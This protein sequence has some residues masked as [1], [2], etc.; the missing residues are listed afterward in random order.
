MKNKFTVGDKV[1]IPK[2][3][4]QGFFDKAHVIIG[5]VKINDKLTIMKF[6]KSSDNQSCVIVKE[7]A[8]YIPVNLI[9]KFLEPKFK[10]GYKFVINNIRFEIVKSSLNKKLKT[11]SYLCYDLDTGAAWGVEEKEIPVKLSVKPEVKMTLAEVS[12]ALGKKV[13]IVN[14]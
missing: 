5:K 3:K 13:I 10:V 12:K 11:Y 2:F 6:V 1:I 9:E 7:C 8:G 4:E 14:D